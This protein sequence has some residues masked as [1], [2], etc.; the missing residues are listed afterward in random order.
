MTITARN[1]FILFATVS[2]AILALAWIF[3]S[4]QLLLV[5]TDMDSVVWLS[6][7]KGV[8]FVVATAVL[9]FFALRAVSSVKTVDRATQ[10]DAVA[11][12]VPKRRPSWL[13]YAVAVAAIIAMVIGLASMALWQG[14]IHSRERATVATQN[15][16]LLLDQQISGRFDKV[17][18]VLQSVAHF[19]QTE[20]AE[21]RFD[22]ARFN[23]Y[24]K[25]KHAL[26]PEVTNLRIIDKDGF[27]RFGNAIP[28]GNPVSLADRDY[29][30]RARTEPASGILVSGPIFARITQEWV[31]V[32]ARRMEAPDGS[33][34]GVVFAALSTSRFSELLSSVEL[35]PHGAAT[36]R[37]VDLAL[38]HRFPQTQG[39]IGSKSVSRE[40]NENIKARPEAG[41]YVATV[42][43]DGIERNNIYRKLERYPFYVIVGLASEDYL[44]GW[45]KDALTLAGLAGLAI[46]ATMLAAGLVYRASLRQAADLEERQRI[47]AELQ[48][49]LA[50]RT[51]LNTELAIR[52][53][54]AEAANR[55]KS[56]FL[57]NMSHEIRTPMNAILGLAY[58]LEK[59]A[60]PGDAHELV[61][62][63]RMAGRSLLGIIND[64]LD[65]SKI[66]SG[67]L[68]I[69]IAPFRLGDV[70]DNLSS[71][72]SANAGEKDFEL[73]IA[74]P[75]SKTS[76]LRG[77][78]LR[79]EQVL[80]NLTSNA[81]KFTERGH[82]ALSISVVAED[83]Q[84][85]TLRFAVRDTGIGIPLEKQQEI[86]APFSQ[87]DGSIGRRFGGTGLGLTISRRLVAGMG[88]ELQVISVPGSG[89]EFW[90][91]L[92]FERSPD[93]WLAA[94]EMAKL[95][96]LIADDNPIAREALRSMVDGLGW[97]ATAVSSGEAAIHHVQT[98]Q[99]Q[100]AHRDVLLLDFK[101]P[102][103]D[104]LATAR[105]IRHELKEAGDPIIIMVTAYS[106]NQLSDHPDSH[107]AD[108][109][110]SKPVTPSS[111]YN[112]V[113][114]AMRVRQGG[115]NQVSSRPRQRLA[116][117]RI[118]VVDD[119][120][121]NRE[122]AQRIFVGEGAQVVLANDGRQA[123]DWLQAHPNEVDIV[124]MDVQMP[125]MNGYEA[126][127][128]IR[129]IPALAELPVIALTAGAFMEQQDL[130]HEAGMNSFIAK[131]FDVDAA[132][133]LIIKLT[134]RLVPV[135]FPEK[136]AP[137]AT[138]LSFDQDLHGLAVGHG[139][140]VWREPSVYQQ[141]LRKFVRDYADIAQQMARADGTEMASLAHK[142]K[143]AA[144]SLALEEITALAGEAAQA[145]RAGEDTADCL[146]RLQ[147]ALDTAL[148]SIE[149][150][151]PP[152]IPA[153]NVTSDA[154]DPAQLG[155]LLGW[156][157]VAWNTDSPG[158][159]RP[160]LAELGKLLLPARFAVFQIAIDNFD[161]RGGE[162]ATRLLAEELG[163][164]PGAR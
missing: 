151:A 67:K 156:L 9:F 120:D 94:P 129:R 41:N 44:G 130:A 38:V 11:G 99:A 146:M 43:F 54:E 112:A 10:L 2:Y 127:R 39:S 133:A 135:A 83:E 59:V 57:A 29:F 102:G 85:V 134:G 93:T 88:G 45:K 8:F 142:L 92:T 25:H 18:V 64:I 78:A 15:V 119:S 55:T 108:A 154:V 42:P 79:L 68:E 139:L 90:F 111:L 14:R 17:D 144:G 91:V 132:I 36:I 52:A 100:R 70:L 53:A 24:V 101:M 116:G 162:Q 46:L 123:I 84:Q 150:Y 65:F 77:D 48:T 158:A 63:I 136:T 71:I 149:R 157:L 22:P 138:A 27:V 51:E 7:A 5:F 147:A 66:E 113:A 40:L 103:M 26:L 3:L 160:L 124:L 143:G 61:H 155:P 140:S 34:A 86:F 50:E 16:A 6:T 163:I 161:F 117:L 89:S 49:L 128:E 74:S 19:Y 104:G 81:I 110:L 76:Q 109:V 82:V 145:L 122:V 98:R 35:G 37:T 141:Y 96:V 105:T 56:A 159:V 30:I 121:I 80:I 137:A 73:I 95:A 87:A 114:R 4:D 72:M 115:E 13:I 148:V 153:E 118:Q 106:S 31:I 125:V 69:E 12:V 23:A 20:T 58:L 126:T 28:T 1:R 97:K 131:P 75:P 33:F 107:L 21:R 164:S 47:D 62:K 60:L 152:G 32:L